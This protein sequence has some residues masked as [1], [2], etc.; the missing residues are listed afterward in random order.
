[1]DAILSALSLRDIGYHFSDK[2]EQFKNISSMVLL[3]KVVEM[4][5]ERGYRLNNLSAVIMAQK[6]KLSPYVESITSS[7][8]KALSV[9]KSAIGIACTTTEKIGLIGREEGIAVNAF[10]SLIAIK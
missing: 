8:A 3:Q 9:D 1:M 2:N 10:C 5:N 6:P 4:M 7:L